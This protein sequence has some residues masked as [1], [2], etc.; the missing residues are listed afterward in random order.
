[1]VLQ[2]IRASLT[3]G[4]YIVASIPNVRYFDHMKT[5]LK[6]KEWRYE[7]AGIL[8][9]THLR[10]F[11]VNSIRELFECC[12][13]EVVSI[14]GIKERQF[15]W[16]FRMLNYILRRTFDDMRFQQFACVARRRSN[17]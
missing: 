2:K 16:K 7:T 1:M 11:T 4:G 6:H 5:L 15:P 13:Y 14:D 17:S 10:F 8:D 9:W 3:A 12:G